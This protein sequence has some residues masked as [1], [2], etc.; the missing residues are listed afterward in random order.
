M[1]KILHLTVLFLVG[2]LLPTVVFGQAPNLERAS[3]F[4]LF[5]KTGAV[6]NT[7]PLTHIL[8]HMGTNGG[9]VSGYPTGSVIGQTYIADSITV[10]TA[11]DVQSAWDQL[12]ALSCPASPGVG[13]AMGG[14]QTITP[15]RYCMGGAASVAGDLILDGQGNPSALFIFKIGG[16]FTAGAAARVLF[17]N[18]ASPNNTYW[19]VHGAATFAASVAFGGTIISS[20]AIGFGDGASL[21]G[22]GF[23]VVGAIS[24]YN[25]RITKTVT[26]APLPVMLT[27]FT[28]ERQAADVQ[29]RWTTASE[30][31]ND[32][33]VVESSSDG[34]QFTQLARLAGHGTSFLA[35]TYQWTDA[36]VARYAVATVYYR[37]RQVDVD[38]TVGYS[39]V[40]AV[41][42]TMATGQAPGLL[43]PNPAQDQ[44]DLR[45]NEA[46]AGPA[47]LR[48]VDTQGRLLAQRPLLLAPGSNTL[49]LYEVRNLRP[50]LYFVQVRQGQQQRTLRLVRE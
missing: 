34:Q 39:P 37:L 19:Q 48:I 23:S 40:R 41:A 47:T 10:Q 26:M 11:A 49:P 28:A 9:A 46:Q 14:G 44:C 42:P 17:I 38:G 13:P 12:E 4:A 29:L 25:N 43:Y 5:T 30:R 50:G 1:Q 2:M 8:G 33:F 32:Y 22:H 18:G 3:G 6:S 35:H 36:Q 15:G 45:L 16:A 7:G 24:T 31:N 20:G 21:V 27:A